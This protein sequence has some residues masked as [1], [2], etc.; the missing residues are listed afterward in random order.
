MSRGWGPWSLGTYLLP[1]DPDWN[2]RL[3]MSEPRLMG[4]HWSST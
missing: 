4:L 3:W 2:K 1:R